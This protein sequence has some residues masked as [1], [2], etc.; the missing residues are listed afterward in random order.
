MDLT[1]SLGT[2]ARG[3]QHTTAQ[4]PSPQQAWITARVDGAPLTARFTRAGDG[5]LLRRDILVDAW[6]PGARGFLDE[7]PLWCGARD[8]WSAFEDSP[9]WDALPSSLRQARHHSP[10]MRLIS[11]GRLFE[12]LCAA[13]LE[14]RVTGHEAIREQRWLARAHGDAAPGPAPRGMA[15]A[16]TPQQVRAIPSWAWHRAGVDPARSRTMALL[17]A[18]AGALARWNRR[19]LDEDLERALRSLPGVGPWTVAET[20]QVTHSDPD[21]VSVADYHL[22]HHV[23]EFF[24]GCRGDDARMLELLEPWRGHR[25]RVVRLL[26]ASQWRAQRM[27]PRLSPEDHRE[28]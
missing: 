25:Q 19:P 13:V 22:A 27:G 7:A 8:D 6:G 17:A 12:A 24:D 20:L 21:R 18:R 28:H 11:T 15:V 16:P 2:L 10:G 14:Q 1:Q 26:H 4:V 9:A 5:D 3:A 23:T